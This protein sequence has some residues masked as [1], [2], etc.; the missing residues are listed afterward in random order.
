MTEPHLND[1]QNKSHFVK[2]TFHVCQLAPLRTT[3]LV[4]PVLGG[5][6]SPRH[7][8]WKRWSVAHVAAARRRPVLPAVARW[9][10]PPTPKSHLHGIMGS[11]VKPHRR[12]CL[13]FHNLIPTWRNVDVSRLDPHFHRIT[14]CDGAACFLWT[15]PLSLFLFQTSIKNPT[16]FHDRSRVLFVRHFNSVHLLFLLTVATQSAIIT[17]G[18]ERLI[19]NKITEVIK[20]HVCQTLTIKT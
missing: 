1:F 16:F 13:H 8:R 4:H 19:N 15:Q 20:V 7:H 17:R 11:R 3:W 6:P 9:R 2:H 12:A 14:S 10:A 5:R 18:E